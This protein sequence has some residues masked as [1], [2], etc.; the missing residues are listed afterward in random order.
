[1]KICDGQQRQYVRQSIKTNSSISLIRCDLSVAPGSHTSEA[2][3]V[4]TVIVA[5]AAVVPLN[6]TVAGEMLHAAPAGAPLHV[7]VTTGLIPPPGV[8]EST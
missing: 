5:V 1:M 4:V 8:R 7:N 3:F 6:V 2:A